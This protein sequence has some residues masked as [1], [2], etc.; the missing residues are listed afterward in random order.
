MPS[1]LQCAAAPLVCP[2][3]AVRIDS[4]SFTIE[5]IVNQIERLIAERR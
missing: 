3:D 5:E 2:E 4:T 1:I